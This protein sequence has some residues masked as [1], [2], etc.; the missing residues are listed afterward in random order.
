[1]NRLI[2]SKTIDRLRI[3]LRADNPQKPLPAWKLTQT[4]TRK[5]K[6]SSFSPSNQDSKSNLDAI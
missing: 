4:Q 6:D 5:T 1:M 2:K 3:T